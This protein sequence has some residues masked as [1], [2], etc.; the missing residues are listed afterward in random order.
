MSLISTNIYNDR[1]YRREK[2]AHTN[3]LSENKNP[4]VSAGDFYYL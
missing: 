3:R 1:S 2:F 4:G